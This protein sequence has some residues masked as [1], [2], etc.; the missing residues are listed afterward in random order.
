VFRWLFKRQLTLDKL[1]H[2]H[3]DVYETAAAEVYEKA[4]TEA[5][6]A[7][8]NRIRELDQIIQ[9]ET[10]PVSAEINMIIER[11]KYETGQRATDISIELLKV[12]AEMPVVIAR[13]Q[14]S[15][16]FYVESPPGQG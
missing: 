16:L 1:K 11:A 3:P 14:M 12:R 2:E 4:T 13:R 9:Y 8:R 10:D 15:R 6:Q 7:E 5:V